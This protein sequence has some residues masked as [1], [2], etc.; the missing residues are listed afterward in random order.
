MKCIPFFSKVFLFPRRK[1]SFKYQRSVFFMPSCLLYIEHTSF[2]GKAYFFVER[3]RKP[4]G[5]NFAASQRSVLIS[6]YKKSHQSGLH[7]T[8]RLLTNQTQGF[9][10]VWQ[11]AIHTLRRQKVCNAKIFSKTTKIFHASNIDQLFLF[12][13]IFY[14]SLSG[15]TYIYLY[16]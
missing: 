11:A 2:L 1:R 8:Q 6:A 5:V 3:K 10:W 7:P 14:R 15:W 12:R 13:L 4:A 9:V 16:V